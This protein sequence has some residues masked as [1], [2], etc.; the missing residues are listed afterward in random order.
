MSSGS[1][2]IRPRAKLF[3]LCRWWRHRR[4]H[5]SLSPPATDRRATARSRGKIDETL[6]Q[7][8]IICRERRL[9]LA[10]R[11]VGIELVIERVIGNARRV[12]E[13]IEAYR[14]RRAAPRSR[15]PSEQSTQPARAG[16]IRGRVLYCLAVPTR[17]S[18][19]MRPS[20]RSPACQPR[21]FGG[22]RRLS[23]AIKLG[24]AGRPRYGAREISPPTTRLTQEFPWRNTLSPIFITIRACR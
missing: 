1:P 21:R 20:P 23:F 4:S 2:V 9:D 14:T 24:I 8:G 17:A 11:Y 3:A 6:G 22:T 16:P 5:R 15:R 7:I 18:P 19:S 12:V 10:F 13:A